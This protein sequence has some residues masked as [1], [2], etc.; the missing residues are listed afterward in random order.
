MRIP[1]FPLTRRY[2]MRGWQGLVAAAAAAAAAAMA[3]A[4]AMRRLADRVVT[5]ILLLFFLGV[6][7]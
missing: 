2:L 4:A 1:G 3:C 7:G 5:G 6:E